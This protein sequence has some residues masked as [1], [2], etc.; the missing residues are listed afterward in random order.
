M[1]TTLEFHENIRFVHRPQLNLNLGFILELASTQ[2]K[3]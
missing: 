1:N 3:S 2:L